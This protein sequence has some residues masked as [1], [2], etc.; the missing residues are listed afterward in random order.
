MQSF[1]ST[2]LSVVFTALLIAPLTSAQTI[3]DDL[4]FNSPTFGDTI[5][6]I[7]DLDDDGFQEIAIAS[8]DFQGRGV[9]RVYAGRTG[10]FRLQLE[11][12]ASGAQYGSAIASIADVDGD[13]VMDF[14]VGAPGDISGSDGPGSIE[15]RSGLT[16]ILLQK[17]WAPLPGAV[18]F[19]GLVKRTQDWDQD[20]IPDILAADQFNTFGQVHIFSSATGAELIRRSVPAASFGEIQPNF[21]EPVGDWN[22]DGAE[23]IAV[24][25]TSTSNF[26]NGVVFIMSLQPTLLIDVIQ[27]TSPSSGNFGSALDA[28]ADLDGDGVRDLVVA[29]PFSDGFAGADSGAF[30]VFSGATRSLIL[31]VEGDQPGARLASDVQVVGDVNGDGRL[32]IA[33]NIPT[34]N[35]GASNELEVFDALTGASLWRQLCSNQ[36]TCATDLAAVGDYNGDGRDDIAIG[37]GGGA[38]QGVQVWISGYT[39]KAGEVLCLGVPNSTGQAGALTSSSPSAYD[40]FANDVTLSVS[41]LPANSFGLIITGQGTDVD[42]SVP[43]NRGRLCIGGSPVG[44]FPVV[45]QASGTGEAAYQPDL[46]NVPIPGFLPSFVQP[47]D[48]LYCQVWYRDTIAAGFSNFTSAVTLTFR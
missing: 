23:D 16:G 7:G 40:A 8:P 20:G 13:G 38:P 39:P 34:F 18:R 12:G 29:E 15:V 33:A 45:L 28:S 22:G 47:G 46:F 2:S 48:T 32:D 4:V 5:S 14:A 27:P 30:S 37:R 25:D 36:V 10:A 21:V 6:A 44:R 42:I 43:S 9:V 1:T 26:P 24:G 3:H 31:R 11:G 41:Q 35:N 17:I 19:G